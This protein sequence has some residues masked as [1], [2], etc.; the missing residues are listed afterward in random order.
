MSRLQDVG[1]A[2]VTSDRVFVGRFG[3]P[4]DEVDS[5]VA[6]WL[7]GASATASHGVMTCEGSLSRAILEFTHPERMRPPGECGAVFA[8][9]AEAATATEDVA[10]A[11]LVAKGLAF[12]GPEAWTRLVAS[13]YL[14][15]VTGVVQALRRYFADADII[16]RWRADDEDSMLIAVTVV[17][18][19]EIDE[20]FER[21]T[22]FDDDWWLDQPLSIRSTIGVY[23]A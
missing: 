21:L 12:D 1:S 20:S 22:R 14:T 5:G 11:S 3:G 4:T 15:A 18:H 8:H 19:A 9:S 7:P 10:F 6:V 16:V 17:D 23:L 13:G 2:S